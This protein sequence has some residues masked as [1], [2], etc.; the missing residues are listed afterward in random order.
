MKEY[1]ISNITSILI[2]LLI[3]IF[4]EEKFKKTKDK[5][6]N[7][8]TNFISKR[9]NLP[10]TIN[11]ESVSKAIIILSILLLVPLIKKWQ[12]QTDF[13]LLLVYSTSIVFSIC[14]IFII[15]YTILEEI[16]YFLRDYC[17]VLI[18]FF[19]L[20]FSKE[21][22]N[23]TNWFIKI[24]SILRVIITIATILYLALISYSK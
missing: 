16:V 1:I 21:E 6:A 24:D 5:L 17:R 2:G 3:G 19:K 11:S 8:L 13:L 9:Y 23:D 4:F 12:H 15:F 14:F 22:F 7:K 10:S 20:L 18:Y